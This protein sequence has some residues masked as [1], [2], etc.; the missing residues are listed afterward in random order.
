MLSLETQVFAL[1]EPSAANLN[2]TKPDL[3]IPI[4]P[5][6]NGNCAPRPSGWPRLVP[7]CIYTDP[8]PKIP[9]VGLKERDSGSSSAGGRLESHFPFTLSFCG[10]CR[11]GSVAVG[12]MAE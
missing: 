7:W 2:L 1:P 8:I 12:L 5:A 9:I 4:I 10:G 11:T 6:Y 3:A